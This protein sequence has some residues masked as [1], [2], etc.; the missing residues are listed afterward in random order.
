MVVKPPL[1]ESD[2]KPDIEREKPVETGDDRGFVGNL[3][4]LPRT[5]KESVVRQSLPDSDRARSQAVFSNLWLHAHA[6]RTHLYSLRPFYTMGLGVMAG[7]LVAI[8]TITG[9]LLMIYYQPSTENAYRSIKDIVYVVPGGMFL[10]NIHRWAAHAMVIVV[11]LHM[12]RVAYTGAYK[13][14]RE[15]NWVI[16]LGLLVLTLALSFTGYLLPWDQLAFWAITVGANIAA[17]PREIT[18]ALGITSQIDIGGLQKQILLGAEHVGEPALVRF[19]VLHCVILPAALFA[20]MGVHFWRSR[21]DGGL[22]RPSWANRIPMRNPFAKDQEGQRPF[23]G[24]STGVKTYGLMALIRGRTPAVSRA[25][26]N[27][28]PSWPYAFLAEAAA[29]MV[30]TAVV[31]LLSLV[32]NAPLKELANPLIPEN[33]AKAPWYFLG[34]QEIVAYSAFA[35]GILIPTIVLIGL[36]LIPYLDREKDEQGIWFTNRLGG[37]IAA[38]SF[39]FALVAAAA[40]VAI[41]VTVGWLRTWFPDIPQLVITIINPGTLLMLVYVA[42]CLL[43]LRRTKSTRMSAIALFSCFL[44]GFIVLTVVGTIFRGPNWEFYWSSSNWPVH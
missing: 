40:A 16:G 24:D 15:F 18:D 3:V 30:I 37:L 33:P 6:V 35:G 9:L 11:I 2:G 29:G 12:A 28:V 34:L 43:V 7:V 27:T 32:F 44:A 22:A 19:Y 42:Y 8:L 26:D 4:Q 14:P 17:S 39:V 23:L 21:K 1:Q 38:K 20:L 25:P 36:G 5:F 41:P 31:F 10:R 13:K